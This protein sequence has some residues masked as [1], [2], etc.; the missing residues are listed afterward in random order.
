MHGISKDVTYGDN[1]RQSAG[2]V[3]YTTNGGEGSSAAIL[4]GG[5]FKTSPEG[6]GSL[7]ALMTSVESIEEPVNASVPRH[8]LCWGVLLLRWC[9]SPLLILL[10]LLILLGWSILLWWRLSVLGRGSS[11]QDGDGC[12]REE[13]HCGFSN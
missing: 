1:P 4:A 12:D 9:G 3:H 6:T 13:L 5:I 2:L 8:R 11:G 7:A 10:R